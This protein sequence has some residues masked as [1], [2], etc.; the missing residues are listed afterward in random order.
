MEEI[1]STFDIAETCARP[2]HI[3]GDRAPTDTAG[4][5]A[6]FSELTKLRVE[7]RAARLGR[8]FGLDAAGLDDVRQQLWLRACQAADRFAPEHGA[9][10][11]HFIRLHLDYEYRDLRRELTAERAGRCVPEAGPCPPWAACAP[12][13]R[14]SS[15]LRLDV[16]EAERALPARRKS[17]T[18]G[19]RHRSPAQV[20]AELGV[21]R[22]TIYRELAEIRDML[23]DFFSEP[24]APRDKLSGGTER[25]SGSGRTGRPS[26]GARRVPD[27]PSMP[28]GCPAEGT[29]RGRP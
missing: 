23:E 29:D 15:D 2:D 16:E 12:D 24:G 8:V 10:L 4:L 5:P 27:P 28:P 17:V 26:A 18:A 3:N 13:H 21:H 14:P 22:G 19:L 20:A 7:H 25:F 6:A 9:S 1:A 11:D